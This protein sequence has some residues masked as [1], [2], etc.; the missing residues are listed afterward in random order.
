MLDL[1]RAIFVYSSEIE[2]ARLHQIHTNTTHP[3][4]L[5]DILPGSI[6]I[7]IRAEASHYHGMQLRKLKSEISASMVEKTLEKHDFSP[8]LDPIP[9]KLYLRK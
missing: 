5:Q 1:L 6:H 2:S 3:S 4:H 8:T 9:L 7:S